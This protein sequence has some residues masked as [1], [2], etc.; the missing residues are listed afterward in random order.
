MS[1]S[2][3]SFRERRQTA[4]K[5]KFFLLELLEFPSTYYL[6]GWASSKQ[7]S[8]Y[9]ASFSATTFP[10]TSTNS[11]VE[12][13]WLTLKKAGKCREKKAR[14]KNFS[15]L[16][17]NRSRFFVAS[18]INFHANTLKVGRESKWI[19][20]AAAALVVLS[21]RSIVNA[22]LSGQT[23]HSPATVRALSDVMC[24]CCLHRERRK[25]MTT[26]MS[27]STFS[28]NKPFVCLS[29]HSTCVVEKKKKKSLGFN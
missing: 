18:S 26:V 24:C 20:A 27:M 17:A 15:A 28:S 12:N 23:Q 13:R 1:E 21:C 5:K 14:K 6:V 11:I 2:R 19:K 3:K 25:L 4:S 10:T 29:M 7:A 9:S 16:I 22:S 8:S